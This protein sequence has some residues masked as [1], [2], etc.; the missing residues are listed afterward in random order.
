MSE[1]LQAAVC[2]TESGAAPEHGESRAPSA[3]R[4]AAIAA[5][6]AAGVAAVASLFAPSVAG[7]QAK[8]KGPRAPTGPTPQTSS[9]TVT[10]PSLDPTSAWLSP[11]LRLARRLSMGLSDTEATRAKQ[12]GY[13]AYLEY[14]L[15]ADQI[16]DSAVE[17]YIATNWPFTQQ[18]ATQLYTQDSGVVQQQ[19]LYSSIYRSA[20]SARALKERMVEFWSDHFNI[21]WEKVTY[22]KLVDD[23][24]VIRANAMT[25]FPKLLKASAHS[26]AMLV[27]LDQNTSRASSPNQNYAREIMELHTLGVDGGYTQTDVA[28]LSRVL[29][30]WTVSARGAGFVFDP[31]L[32]DFAS[33]TILG[34]TIPAASTSTGVAAQQEGEQMIDYL[35]NHASTAKFIAKKMLRYFLRYDPSAQQIAEVAASYTSSGGD[36]KA[37]LRVVLS[38][39][40]LASAPAKF[41]RPFHLVAST[42]RALGATVALGGFGSVISLISSAG[43]LPFEWATPDGYPDTIEFW[44]GNMLPRW[45]AASYFANANSATSVQ[46]NVTP[47]MTPATP[48]NIVANINTYLFAGEMSSRLTDELTAYVSVTPTSTTRVR[49]TIALALSSSSFQYY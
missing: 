20:F 11:E 38:P 1:D 29:T 28:E 4:R 25:T 15:N 8:A 32:H 12:M 23:R 16:D 45:N 7:A 18:S 34:V 26:P 10:P 14:Q 42:L 2:E 37:M 30:G 3:D 46:F 9:A 31:N 39:A 24:D 21:Q 19:L 33:K 43:H 36:V 35:L 6:V 48:A 41:K 13:S 40:N 5:G 44:S 27:Y 22:M 47:W 17:T 49:E